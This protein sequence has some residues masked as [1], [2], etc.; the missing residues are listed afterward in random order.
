[1]YLYLITNIFCFY[2]QVFH[3]AFGSG[4]LIIFADHL[5]PSDVLPSIARSAVYGASFFLPQV[6]HKPQLFI[7]FDGF[8]N[9]SC[10]LIPIL[11]AVTIV[12]HSVSMNTFFL[13][14]VIGYN[15]SN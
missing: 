3:T 13:I 12:H 8:Q 5:I 10:I 2:S 9:S 11:V 1:M 4:F 15:F 14:S 7:K 6:T